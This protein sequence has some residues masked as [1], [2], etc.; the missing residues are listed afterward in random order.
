MFSNQ[1]VPITAMFAFAFIVFIN[2][3]L[4]LSPADK[5]WEDLEQRGTAAL[6][7]NEYW[8]AEPLLKK[9]WNRPGL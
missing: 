8:I 7:A 6:D 3:V 9:L 4:A 2:P 1:F 5:N